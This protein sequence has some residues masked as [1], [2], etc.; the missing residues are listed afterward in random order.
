MSANGEDKDKAVL[1]EA[2]AAHAGGESRMAINAL[3]QRINA[4]GGRCDV[5]IWLSVLDLYLIQ[6]SQAPYEK[7]ASHFADLFKFSAPPW[8][9]FEDPS[10][11]K[12]FSASWRNAL[13]IEGSPASVHEDKVRDF[14]HA[15]KEQNASRL[16]LSRMR[17][18]DRESERIKEIL[19]L[20]SVMQRLRRHKCPT[21]LM[22]EAELV[23]FL[24]TRSRTGGDLDDEIHYWTLLFEIL[25][26]R[27]KEDEFDVLAMEF[28]E[29]YD[30]CHVGFDPTGAIGVVPKISQETGGGYHP[31]ET[32]MDGGEIMDALRDAW[33]NGR[34]VSIDL[35]YVKRIGMDAA[36]GVAE[37]LQAQNDDPRQVRFVNPIEPLV[38][39]LEMAGVTAFSTVGHRYPKVRTLAIEAGPGN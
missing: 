17:L 3:I 27:G 33:T 16:D 7:L 8:E 5:R 31:P 24:R 29:K 1:F 9:K 30:Y 13:I 19:T 28:A 35:S 39:L 25:Q 15:S 6:N 11:P 23:D 38:T 26:W 37:L 14:L 10:K 22:G 20:T 12:E 4:T 18:S 21:L 36:R 2:A 32:I 34:P